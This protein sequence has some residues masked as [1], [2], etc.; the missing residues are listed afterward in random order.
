MHR[1]MLCTGMKL[2]IFAG[3]VTLQT[4]HN[5]Q[6]HASVHIWVLAIGLL[7]AS[8][9]R[10]AEHIDVWSPEWQ[11][12][13]LTV[14]PLATRKGILCTSL[15]THSREHLF[16]KII[17]KRS[18]HSY[19]RREYRGKTVSAN[20]MK[21]LTPPVKRR[22]AKTFD[23]RRTIHHQQWFLLKSKPFAQILRP[24][25]SGQFMILIRKKLRRYKRR[26]TGKHNCN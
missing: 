18:S 22:D 11:S 25:L 23:S 14:L 20:P 10:V 2:V 9:S 15:I 17:V 16:D 21:S 5:T 26:K 3:S 6:S 1:I 24:L 12:F 4:L 7:A 13:I 19:T 8:P